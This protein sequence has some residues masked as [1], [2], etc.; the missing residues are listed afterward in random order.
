MRPAREGPA[1]DDEAPGG[2]VVDQLPDHLADAEG[3]DLG[4]EEHP[5]QRLVPGAEG[6]HVDALARPAGVADR[7]APAPGGQARQAAL[8]GVAAHRVDHEVGTPPA[9]LLADAVDP[10]GLAVVDRAAGTTFVIEP[11]LRFEGSPGEQWTMFV[12]D[13]AG[14]PLEFKAF[15]D[16]AQVFAR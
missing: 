2:H 3:R 5:G 4:T 14:N 8:Q 15:A 12:L 9:G 7:D 11:Y 13:P 16:D 6:R 1:D 10:A